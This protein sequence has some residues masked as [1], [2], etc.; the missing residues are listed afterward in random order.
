MRQQQAGQRNV[1]S[2]EIP[3]KLLWGGTRAVWAPRSVSF[4]SA[5]GHVA[6]PWS[7]TCSAPL[8]RVSRSLHA[9]ALMSRCKNLLKARWK[10]TVVALQGN[11]AVL[12]ELA[13]RQSRLT[14]ALVSSGSNGADYVVELP[15]LVDEGLR[16]KSPGLRGVHVQMSDWSHAGAEGKLSSSREQVLASGT[17][18]KPAI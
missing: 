5:R 7:Y 18:G 12:F 11:C 16:R 8:K 14:S 10:V 9:A 3:R 15:R 17:S 6:V 1:G 2:A 4:G 13:K